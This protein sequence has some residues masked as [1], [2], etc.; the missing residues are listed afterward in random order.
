MFVTYISCL[1]EI[2]KNI[3]KTPNDQPYICLECSNEQLVEELNVSE[4]I[5][6]I[7]ALKYRFSLVSNKYQKANVNS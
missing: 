1:G 5:H 2:L 4:I 7:P 6:G 3:L